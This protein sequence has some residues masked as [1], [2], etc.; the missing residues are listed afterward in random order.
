MTPLTRVRAED[1]ENNHHALNGLC[2]SEIVDDLVA[3]QLRSWRRS[4]RWLVSEQWNELRAHVARVEQLMGENRHEEAIVAAQIAANHAVIWHSGLYA[5]PALEHLIRRLGLAMLATS[6]T[7]P[8]RSDHLRILHVVSEVGAIG[9]HT[10][11]LWRWIGNDS[12]NAHSVA[13]TRQTMQTPG[14]IVAA[15]LATGGTVSWLNRCPGGIVAWA[16]ELQCAMRN[17]DLVILHAHNYDI[18]PFLAMAGMR[19]RPPVALLNHCDHLF[20]LGAEFADAVVNTRRS[21]HVLCETRRGIAPERNLLLPLCLEGI[22]RKPGRTDL[23]HA[24]GMTEE[25]VV[26]LSIARAVKF[27]PI[28]GVGFADAIAPLLRTNPKARLLVIGP[29]GEADWTAAMTVAPGQILVLP[30]LPD[31]GDYFE[32]AD[33]YL[34]SFPFPSNTSILEAGLRELPLVSWCVFG[35]DCGVMGADSLGMDEVLIRAFSLT[36]LYDRLRLLLNDPVLRREVGARTCH[37]I[38]TINT[39]E[40]WNSALSGLYEKI[41]DLPRKL[42]WSDVPPFEDPSFTDL[43]MFTP[44]VF[45]PSDPFP[46]ASTRRANVTE[47]ALRIM[48]PG[49]RAMVLAGLV[50]NRQMTLRPAGAAWRYMLPEWLVARMRN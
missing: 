38:K 16:R 36:D 47:Q 1:P 48:P 32:I 11:M 50:R 42:A 20:W 30:E 4:G 25:D 7:H 6:E 35:P 15:A 22:E 24:L 21:G 14:V 19:N 9:G 3:D 8:P 34:D 2:G 39:K 28:G 49:R 44:F 27:R 46:T 45:G 12:R 29:G 17:A 33:I 26:I 23:R 43:D 37:A 40:N 31:V 10:R 41:L 18:V 5:S 13:L